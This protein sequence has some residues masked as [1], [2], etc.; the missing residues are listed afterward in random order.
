MSSSRTDGPGSSR[1]TTTGPSRRL[2]EGYVD[3][4]QGRLADHHRLPGLGDEPVGD[5]PLAEVGGP[6]VPA[7]LPLERRDVRVVAV[8]GDRP[9]DERVERLPLDAAEVA[10]GHEPAVVEDA[11]QERP[12][13]H[14][15]VG[16]GHLGVGAELLVVGR[17]EVVGRHGRQPRSR[18]QGNLRGFRLR[19]TASR[20]HTCPVLHR[21]NLRRVV[22]ASTIALLIAA[23]MA[24]YVADIAD[25]GPTRCQ[26]HRLEARERAGVVTG[27]GERVL[28]IGDSWSVGLGQDDLSPVVGRSGSRAR[29]T[30][31]ASPARASAP[32]P[33]AAVASPS[34]TARRP[35]S[36]YVPGWWWS[37]AA[38]TTTT[39]PPAPS[40]AASVS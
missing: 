23:L 11:P 35:R 8:V 38:S 10:V 15:L 4:E 5:E 7:R 12:L 3:V 21:G 22:G 34:T 36:A 13:T 17:Q 6:V 26:Q 27:R 1:R 24:F 14:D 33:A 18:S 2:G 32:G 16:P 20:P 30:S 31:A 37:R 39:S 28:V 40:T 9:L 25:A 29:S 19:G